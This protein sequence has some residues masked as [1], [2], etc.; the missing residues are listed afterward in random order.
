MKSKSFLWIYWT[1]NSYKNNINRRFWLYWDHF[2]LLLLFILLSFNFLEMVTN[3][4]LFSC[5]SYAQFG[6]L[7]IVFGEGL[8]GGVRNYGDRGLCNCSILKW[9]VVR[10]RLERDSPFPIQQCWSFWFPIFNTPFVICCLCL[11]CFTMP[12]FPTL[13]RF[14]Y[15]LIPV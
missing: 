8:G 11:W 6:V 2:Y 7:D 4:S 9:A 3:C 14:I 15:T 5:R 12:I 10:D 1:Y 13:P